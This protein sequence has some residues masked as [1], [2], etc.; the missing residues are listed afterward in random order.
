MQASAQ[1]WVLTVD[2]ILEH[3][4]AA[5]PQVEIFTASPF[6]AP[7]RTDYAELAS[8]VRRLAGALSAGGLRRGD[9]A[10]VIGANTARQLEAWYAVMGLGA[11]CHPLNPALPVEA[12]AAQLVQSSPKIAFVEPALL[13]ALEPTLRSLPRL[14]RVVVLAEKDEASD[15]GLSNAVSHDA[16]VEQGSPYL[17]SGVSETDPAVMI[18]TAG[19]SDPARTVT[20]S[21]RA[22]V[23]QA[24]TALGPGGLD[25]SD[26]E[27]I[28][29][30]VPFW[31][32]AAWGLVF[33]GPMAGAKLVLPG[34]KTD[35]QSVRVLADREAASMIVAAPA[36]LQALHDQYRSESRRPNGLQR[37]IA[38]GAPSAPGL[39]KAWRDNFSVDASAAWGLAETASMGTVFRPGSMGDAPPFGLELQILGHDGRPMPRDGAS[40]GRLHARGATSTGAA[41]PDGF[42]DTGDLASIDAQGR[43]RVLGRADALVFAAGGL[44][45]AELIEAAAIDHPS[46]AMAAAIDPPTGLAQEGPVLVVSRKP[47]AV[48]GKA[49]LLRFVGERLGP[50]TPKDVLWVDGFPLDPAGRVDR[51]ALRE[52]LERLGRQA[53]APA[54]APAEPPP[55][56]PTLEP[57]LATAPLVFGAAAAFAEAQEAPPAPAIAEATAAAPVVYLAEPQEPAATE[58]EPEPEP[59]AAAH[60]IEP[61]APSLAPSLALGDEASAAADLAEPPAPSGPGAHDAP[62]PDD[63][64]VVKATLPPAPA[65]APAEPSR[66]TALALLPTSA[67][68]IPAAAISADLAEPEEELRPLRVPGPAPQDFGA[69]TPGYRL[70]RPRRDNDHPRWAQWFL[71]I[72]AILGGVPLAMLALVALGLRV[73]LIDWRIGL[74]DEV[75]DWP[76]RFALVGVVGGLLAIFAALFAGFGRFWRRALLSLGGPILVMAALIWLS[77]IQQ[78][79]PPL[80][81]VATDWTSPITFSKGLIATRGPGADPVDADP[82]IPADGGRFMNRR[83]ADVNADTCPQAHPVVL[84]MTP[85]QAYARVKGAVTG[86]GLTVLTDDPAQGRLEATWTNAWLGFRNDLAV[87]IRTQGGETRVDF[88]SVSRDAASDFGSNCAEVS[89]LVGMV[90]GR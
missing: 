64:V 32:A 82:V 46:T 16:L 45:P 37:V 19:S 8:R 21:H 38:V 1:P 70:A 66:S 85:V 74:T 76:Y 42:V 34:R 80:H 78:S 15:S 68:G 22:C 47:G 23:L 27:A 58:P 73:G 54:E 53:E 43:V 12:L 52:R 18:P 83:V 61:P 48:I 56:I 36:E 49:E 72:T 24:L 77:L 30:L 75:L 65:P 39:A 9:V 10:A 67:A 35:I 31:R 14:E 3:A 33:A 44:A 87:R 5:R 55:V 57:A 11:V 2:R 60:D 89:R 69:P 86:D 79:Y 71:S 88:R 51:I 59:R 29:P 62:A 84:A 6:G 40:V 20:W 13:P 50:A 17:W 26:H 25:L 63:V 4:A 7:S 28:L 41:G 90:Q 81:D